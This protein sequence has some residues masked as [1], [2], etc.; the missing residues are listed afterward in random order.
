MLAVSK[1]LMINYQEQ[2]FLITL[3]TIKTVTDM[4]VAIL[5]LLLYYIFNIL[6]GKYAENIIVYERKTRYIILCTRIHARSK[7]KSVKLAVKI[8][9]QNKT[10]NAVY[11]IW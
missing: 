3:L 6:D 1:Q 2:L 4:A 10:G 5:V 11:I 8:K 9:K 7:L